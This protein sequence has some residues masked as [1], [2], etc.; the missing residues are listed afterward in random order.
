MA[1]FQVSSFYYD[2]STNNIFVQFTV[3]V[4][5]SYEYDVPEGGGPYD[6]YEAQIFLDAGHT[7]VG[8]FRPAEIDGEVPDRIYGRDSGTKPDDPQPYPIEDAPS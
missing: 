1:Y 2:E 3:P 5:V 7:V 6:V 8:K 4:D